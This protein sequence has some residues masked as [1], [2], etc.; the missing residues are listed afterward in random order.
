LIKENGKKYLTKQYY[1]IILLSINLN[2]FYK[3]TNELKTIENLLTRLWTESGYPT[4][5]GTKTND[6]TT[7]KFGELF[8][9]TNVTNS[10]Y[11]NYNTTYNETPTSYTTEN[12]LTWVF[13]LPGF[14]TDNLTVELSNNK[15]FIEGRRPLNTTEETFETVSKTYTVDTTTYDFTNSTAEIKDGILTVTF[16]KYKKDKKKVL[17]LI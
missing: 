1:Y 4:T 11:K 9:P 10:W 16:P 13:E 15:L 17:T 7:L 5:F 2:N 3:M 14:N 8:T 6:L 12:T